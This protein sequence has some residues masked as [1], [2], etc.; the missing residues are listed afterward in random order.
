MWFEPGRRVAWESVI[1]KY[2]AQSSTAEVK[3]TGW[4]FG[5]YINQVLTGLKARTLKDDLTMSTPDLA[6]RLFKGNR[7]LPLTGPIKNA[8]VTPNPKIHAYLTDKANLNYGVS[9]V[10]V[11]FDLLYNSE[12]L[13]KAKVKPPT[14]PEEL[15]AVAKKLTKKPNQY[16]FWHPNI[17]AE[18]GDFWFNLQNWVNMYDGVW[19]V[20][21]TPKATP[22]RC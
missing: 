8:G 18:Q 11:N 9:I 3:L 17:M 21:K 12:I 5:Q 1:G 15:L 13:K 2:N 10:T 7:F 16:G 6:A 20:G 4:P 19:A 14:T 22:P